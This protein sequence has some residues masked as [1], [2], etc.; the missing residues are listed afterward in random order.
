[1]TEDSDRE[2]DT[3]HGEVYLPGIT[4]RAMFAGAA[5]ITFTSATNARGQHSSGSSKER[6]MAN[7][8]INEADYIPVGPAT[9]FV[10]FSPVRF[11]V[12]GRQV[13]LQIR[14]AAPAAGDNLPIILLSHGHGQSTYLSSLRGYGP[15]VDFY[16]A[17][18]FVV[19][20]PT[21][22]DSKALGL[23][24]AGPEGALFWRSR[25]QDMRFIL[26]HLD[27]IEATVPGLSGRLDQRRVAAIGHSL[28]GHTVGMLCGMRVK[29]PVTSEDVSLADR[30]VKAGV[31]LAPPGKGADLAAFASEHYPVLR[32]SSF[33][34]MT[35]P[36]LI[37]AGD[38]DQS[39]MFALRKDWRADAYTLSAGRKSLLTLFDAGHSLGGVSGYDVR[40]STDQDPERLGV[41]QRLTW[42]YVRSELYPGDPAWSEACTA[43]ARQ[44][45]PL[46]KVESK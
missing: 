14:V 26:D 43:L 3:P 29:D 33:A 19:I 18:G 4:R 16:A 11:W 8:P 25:A 30:R 23:D 15:L 28:G 35:T 21:H 22:Q 40:E 6:T 45:R 34:E 27:Q 38:K 20:Q 42:A 39:D 12:P 5:G 13:D 32:N 2:P 37:V 7:T 44:P 10:S 46:G 9:P 31:Q 36:A 41:V 24:P 17:H 1:M